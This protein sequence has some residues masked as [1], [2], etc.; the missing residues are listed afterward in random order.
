MTRVVKTGTL[1]TTSWRVRSSKGVLAGEG[2]PDRGRRVRGLKLVNDDGEL[3]AIIDQGH[4]RQRK[5]RREDPRR[6]DH[7]SRRPGRQRH[8]GQPRQGRHAAAPASSS[9][10]WARQRIGGTRVSGPKTG[11]DTP[12]RLFLRCGSACPAPPTASGPRHIRRQPSAPAPRRN[13]PGSA[14]PPPQQLLVERS[15][16][17]PQ[18]VRFALDVESSR[19]PGVDPFFAPPATDR[20]RREPYGH[21]VGCPFRAPRRDWAD[22]IRSPLTPYRGPTFAAE[23]RRDG[24]VDSCLPN[25]GHIRGG[26]ARV[27]TTQETGRVD[28]GPITPAPA[29]HDGEW[30]ALLIRDSFHPLSPLEQNGHDSS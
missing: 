27:R 2:S 8:E 14:P 11:P 21:V 28:R 24:S 5:R 6:Q 1:S 15:R 19:Y 18:Q 13:G 23:S 20:H 29:R 22:S 25:P 9:K 10:S 12:S 4:R 3:S 30:P 7:R 17:S 26:F 16:T